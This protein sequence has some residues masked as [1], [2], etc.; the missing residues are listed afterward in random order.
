MDAD[1]PNDPLAMYLREVAN[2]ERFTTK[3]QIELFRQ[4]GH[5][6]NWGERQEDIARRLLESQLWLV[7][8][9]AE[10]HQGAGFSMLDL[11]QEGNIGLMNAVRSFAEKPIGDFATHAN[12]CIEDAFA[13]LMS[14]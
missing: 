11:I 6:G 13:K 10:R 7:V 8:Q 2:V 12:A 1:A 5:S 3:E 4:L 14:K 9:I